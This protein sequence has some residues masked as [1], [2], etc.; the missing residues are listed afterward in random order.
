VLTKKG[1]PTARFTHAMQQVRDWRIWLRKN[2]QYAQNQ[3][4]YIGL[5]SEFEAI[6]VMGR[7]KD[8]NPEHHEKYRELSNEKVQ[9]MSYDRMIEYTIGSAR[10]LYQT[11]DNL[12]KSN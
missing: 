1:Q 10:S 9:V 3:L 7:R 2:I 6:I 8:L 5:D 12:T 11:W 4:G